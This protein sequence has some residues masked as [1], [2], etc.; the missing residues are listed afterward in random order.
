MSDAAPQPRHADGRGRRMLLGAGLAALLP[1]AMAQSPLR[2]VVPSPPG[3]PQDK[4]ARLLA[5][6]LST[7][8]NEAVL[9][10]NRPGAESAIATEQVIGAQPPDRTLLITSTVLALGAVQEKF[11]FDPLKD[12]KP[13]IQAVDMDVMLVARADLPVA[14]PADLIARMKAGGTL[15]CGGGLGQMFLACLQLREHLGTGLTTVPFNGIAKVVN[16]L[17]GG[18]IDI[19][20]V[21]SNDAGPY[22]ADGRLQ[23]LAITGHTSTGPKYAQ[24]PLVKATWPDIALRSYMALY[25]PAAA[26][27][28]AV[29]R[30]NADVNAILQ[31]QQVQD[32]LAIFDMAPV[33]GRP[34]RL[35]TTLLQNLAHFQ[36]LK[37]LLDAEGR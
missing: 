7:M 37:A 29:A 8:R 21:P 36:S 28:D 19:G 32:T 20:V 11:R 2:I 18:H 5:R 4:L 17:L 30:W 12:L 16:A 35:K 24:L 26:S 14:R 31:Q 1:G 22:I 33:G 6:H 23:A 25:A 10:D 15:S 9:V 13:V 27:D 3:G 34:E